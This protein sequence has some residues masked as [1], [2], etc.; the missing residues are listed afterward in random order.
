MQ[1][2]VFI[3]VG[4]VCWLSFDATL[5]RGSMNIHLG[6][7]CVGLIYIYRFDVIIN[8]TFFCPQ[9]YSRRC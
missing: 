8:K 4:K 7:S 9:K 1:G 3:S 5:V 6:C 2:K